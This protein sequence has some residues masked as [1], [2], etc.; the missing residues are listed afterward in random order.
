M[1]ESTKKIALIAGIGYL[2]IFITGIYANFF[3]LENLVVPGDAVATTENITNNATQFRGGI[4]S[5]ILMV[6]FDVVLAWALY[7]LFK[8]VNI[9]LAQ[10]SAWLRLVNATIFGVALYHLFSVLQLTGSLDFAS[11]FTPEQLQGH[12]M[13]S[14]SAFNYTWLLGL[15]FFGIH[16]LFLGYL[17]IQSGKMPK[18][19]GILLIIAGV[20]YL[21]DSFAHFMMPNYADYENLFAMLVIVPGVIGELSFTVWLLW[22][23]L[24][25]KRVALAPSQA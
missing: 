4:L 12:V 6:A 15:V 9:S 24:R 10:L 8:S 19:L 3:I 16:L 22:R 11:I 20:G 7:I 25:K 21:I 17:I 5:F 1:M 2:V 23:G 13:L 14:L 18:V